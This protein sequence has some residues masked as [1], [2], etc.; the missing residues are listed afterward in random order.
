MIREGWHDRYPGTARRRGRSAAELRVQRRSEGGPRPAGVRHRRS[1]L[2]GHR[3]HP[4]GPAQPAGPVRPRAGWPTR[5][6]SRS[7]R[8]TRASS[9]RRRPRSRPT[10]STSIR[11]TSSSWPSRA[12]ATRS[13]RTFGVLGMCSRQYA[14]HIPFIVKLNHNELLTYPNEFDQIMFG[15]VE[16]AYDLGAAGVGATIYFGADESHRQIIEVSEAFQQAHE[17]GHVHR[18]VV[19]PAQLGLQG[20]RRRLPRRG[21]PHRPGQPP[22]RHHRGRHHQAEAADEERRLQRGQASARPAPWSTTS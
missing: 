5:A 6:T 9:T 17:L 3:P 19:L 15:S 18:A 8:S 16:Q 12:A 14:H 4:A 22:R 21:R 13:R 2:Q 20:G 11:R 7:S 10:R 1:G